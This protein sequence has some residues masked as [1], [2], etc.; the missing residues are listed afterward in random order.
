MEEPALGVDGTV[1]G[2]AVLLRDEIILQAVPRSGVDRAGPL[3]ER[4][5]LGQDPGGFP[6]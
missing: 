6:F 2:D 3:F 4:D 1:G 5:V